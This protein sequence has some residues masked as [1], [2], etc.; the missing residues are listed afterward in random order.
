MRVH[1]RLRNRSDTIHLMIAFFVIKFIHFFVVT[2]TL[3]IFFIVFLM[4][5]MLM[6]LVLVILHPLDVVMKFDH[7]YVRGLNYAHRVMIIIHV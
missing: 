2:I 4:M 1:L 3:I 5:Y 6:T 7:F